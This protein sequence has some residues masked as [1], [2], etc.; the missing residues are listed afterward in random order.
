MV[1]VLLLG[2]FLKKFIKYVGI[3]LKI[4]IITFDKYKHVASISAHPPLY[5]CSA[6]PP[7]YHCS[8]HPTL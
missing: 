4:S 2:R 5:H 6:H 3:M 8:A 7:L 1:E